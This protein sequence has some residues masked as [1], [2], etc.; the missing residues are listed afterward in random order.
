MGTAWKI[1]KWTVIG[2]TGTFLAA[3][4]FLLLYIDP[5][6]YR[7]DASKLVKEKTGL[8]LLINGDIGWQFYPA[9]GFS[10]A[11]LSLATAEGEPALA[12]I[13]SAAV[14][15]EL[16]PLLNKQVNVRTL[17]VDK[18]VA[19][20]VV[21]PEGKGNWEA[22]SANQPPAEPEPEPAADAAKGGGPVA[23]RIPK[24]V[25]S[26]TIIDYEDQKSL[27]HQTVTIQ[28]LVAENVGLGQEFPFHLIG[29]L[30]DRTGISVTLDTRAFLTLNPDA[31]IYDVRGF[32]LVADVGGILAKPFH[33]TLGADVAADMNEKKIGITRMVLEAANLAVT[34]RPLT[35]KV[36]GPIAVD[37]AADTAT[38]GPFAF[39]AAGVNGKLDVAV[40][41][42]TKEL[43]FAGNLDI[44]PFN[45]KNAMRTVGIKPPETTDAL[46]MTKVAFKTAFDGA[47][48]RA[49][50][51]N[52]E[53]TLDDTHVKGSAGITDVATKAIVFDLNVDG[54]NADRYLPPVTKQPE[55]KTTA[56]AAAPV[57]AAP[58]KP[59]GKAEPL[60]PVETL[61]TLNVDGK[62]G[63]GRIT[64][65][66]WPMTNL[67]LT[68]KA[69]DGNVRLDPF[70]ASVLEGTVSGNVRI[71]ATGN[72]PRIVTNLK[73][74]RIEVGG[75][76]KRYAKKDLLTG[77]TSLNLA[78]DTTG[79]D[80]DTLIKRAVGTVDFS[81]ADAVLKGANLNGMLTE[82]L[83]Q[84]LGAFS[85]LVPDYQQKLPK[86]LHED[87][88]FQ[89]LS[90][91]ASV[92]DGI[93]QIPA[94]N[95]TV[96]DGAVRGSGQFNLLLLD[97]DYTLAMRTDKL[98]DNK[99]LGNLEFPVH[100]K[101]NIAGAPADWCRPD[102]KAITRTLKD[103]AENA[104]KDRLK[105]ELAKRLGIESTDTAAI[106]AEVQK[107]IDQKVEEQKAA[108]EKKAKEQLNKEMQKA[109]QKYF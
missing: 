44:A 48:T 88:A 31:Q 94:F 14:S 104:A 16:M 81:F 23:I 84:Q 38:V 97:F 62:L 100:C 52:I 42:L 9:I 11:E 28:E 25:I 55:A 12:S 108:A 64:L 93:A 2:L 66:E 70:S 85:M 6:D 30:N 79:N 27:A 92:K 87:T 39:S 59:A 106:K 8:V 58:Q 19:N 4:V 41:N 10:V 29:K 32:E 45:A 5:N 75:V 20:L 47:L 78:M 99:Y 71:D 95:A 61:R 72:D 98:K 53:I 103:A 89:T 22:L 76:V 40:T 73:L 37:L 24:I 33:L 57:A 65:M 109:F 69:K 54:I 3:V 86:Q 82:T 17:Y 35:V 1:F 50:L 43:A 21:N 101:G 102:T 105:G 80:V 107:Q 26:N 74:N 63:V 18:L 46:A 15:V 34:E 49:M 67:A 68:L 96:K 91:K 7:D 83:S 90:A 13:G 36:E 51:N 60:L 77:K 56:T